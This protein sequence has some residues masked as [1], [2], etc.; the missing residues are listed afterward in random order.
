MGSFFGE[1]EKNNDQ[2]NFKNMIT[3]KQ[4]VTNSMNSI[5]LIF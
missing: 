3:G 4:S 5:F 1:N 2:L